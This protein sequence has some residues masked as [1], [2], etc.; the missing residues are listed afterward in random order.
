[1]QLIKMLDNAKGNGTSMISLI[2]P[3]KSQVSVHQLSPAAVV[4]L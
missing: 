1:M 2:L 4:I 3:P